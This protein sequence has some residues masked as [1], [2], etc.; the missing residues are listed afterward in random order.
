[1]NDDVRRQICTAKVKVLQL[2][3]FLHNLAEEDCDDLVKL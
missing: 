3:V 1:M 2:A